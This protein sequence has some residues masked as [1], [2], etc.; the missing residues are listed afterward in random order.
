MKRLLPFLLA[1]IMLLACLAACQNV[2]EPNDGMQTQDPTLSQDPTSSDTT[3]SSGNQ[4]PVADPLSLVKDGATD[5]VIV[6]P[7]NLTADDPAFLA[8]I[9]LRDTIQEITGAVPQIV[10]DD[11]SK[12]AVSDKEIIIGNARGA[13]YNEHTVFVKESRLYIGG[14]S[15]LLSDMIAAFFKACLD[16]NIHT[17]AEVHMDQIEIPVDLTMDQAGNIT[18]QQVRKDETLWGDSIVYADEIANLI[19][20]RYLDQKRTTAE[21]TN[22]DI[23]LI[24][25]LGQKDNKQVAGLYNK[26]GV[27]YLTNTMDAFIVTESGDKLYASC[28]GSNARGNIYR[29]GYYY[30]DIHFL[31]QGF[32]P[33]AYEID[34]SA[35][36]YNLLSK[37][38]R[39]S[40]HDIESV[41]LLD[42]VLTAIVSDTYDPYFHWNVSYNTND[43][44]AIQLT[45]RTEYAT[46]ATL[47]F[48]A[49][50]YA[51]FNSDQIVSFSVA[52]G[53]EYCTYIVPLSSIPD[54]T[55]KVEAIRVD[56]G[57]KI[58]EKI[59]IKEM[60]AIK[61]N[62]TAATS[63]KLD[64]NL[65]V[66][67]DKLHQQ[68]RVVAEND[69]I[70]FKG[71]GALTKI[72]ASRVGALVIADKNGKHN[73]IDEIDTASVQYV[74]FDLI[75]A[76]VFG[77]IFPANDAYVGNV[78][79]TLEDGYY[80]IEQTYSPSSASLKALDSY[81][82][83]H[84][85]YT[86]EGHSFDELERQAYIE[87]NPLTDIK[88]VTK[89]DNANYAGYNSLVGC[90]TF[91]LNGSD[92]N[93]A[94]YNEPQKHFVVDAQIAG[95][96]YDR[97]IYVFAHSTTSGALESGVVLDEQNRLLPINVEVCKNFKGEY[98]EPLFDPEDMHYGY[99]IFPVTISKNQTKQFKSVNLYQNWGK[100]PLK[101]LSSI[102]F[103][104]PYYHLSCGVT[105]TNCIAPYYVYGKDYWT[106]PDFRAMSSPL[107]NGQPQHTS[108]GR[109]Y[110]LQY[111][112]A[113]GNFFGSESQRADISS[114]GP[115]YVDIDMS[116]LSD[117]GKIQVDYR[118]VEHAQ[119]DE[120]RTYYTLD[121]T[122][123]EDLEIKD[124]VNNFSFFSMDGR[125]IVYKKLG[126]LDENNQPQT[127]E[128]KL[129]PHTDYYK[130]GKNGAYFDYYI[131]S[132]PAH[133]TTDSVNM[134]VVI[135]DY[136]IVLGGKLYDGN[137]IL[138]E[139]YDGTVN[140]ATL[141]LDA[142]DITLRAG[143]TVHID[144]ILL[145]WGSPES[146]DDSNV[147]GVREDSVISPI[148]VKAK[149]GTVMA[150]TYLPCVIAD[151]NTA[152]FTVSD[153]GSAV[154]AVRIYGFDTYTKPNIQVYE[155]GAWIDYNYQHHDYD[156]YMSFRED[157]GTYS[158]AF[159]FEITDG[160][161][162]QFRVSQ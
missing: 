109:L 96:A 41:K 22:G 49:G 150:D 57:E 119:S 87:R 7:A 140:L 162:R 122:V 151:N 85:I 97:E 52:P 114:S 35:G 89:S 29:F 1:L 83:G 84:R 33:T 93:K 21:I 123:L 112:D 121:L 20:F 148:S 108:A 40:S 155:D 18:T 60:K 56:C 14:E 12:Y 128:L 42:D 118:Q 76:G 106:L 28:S 105:E 19:N 68:I 24:Y 36:S 154:Y 10:T 146:K 71:F 116:Y 23:L 46:N 62:T 66:Y 147:L 5:Y 78:T 144:M 124:F 79:V 120:T 65:H 43:Y 143:D 59:E 157:D 133:K 131:D 67:G 156:G 11:E 80:F 64:R 136:Q 63:M 88:I 94:Y 51:G 139:Q 75:D 142:G 149:V 99:S 125:A 134:A 17:E 81:S 95:D 107:W 4:A 69:T 32:L 77:Y 86:D 53:D 127:V 137:L 30:Y 115:V 48:K 129:E 100:F 152:E 27:P 25:N 132:N 39:P 70:G 113:D 159:S 110:W 153:G 26:Q 54:Y 111:T 138:K 34:E 135:K 103:I 92:F 130:L 6:R 73:T 82:I 101:Q 126:Y 15:Q 141:T 98:E 13:T 104:A 58:G 117:D 3:A 90:Y 16:Y 50:S 9:L 161:S 72:E 74:G 102:Q 61:I 45:M 91:T 44:N 55:G 31:N 37:A 145:P 38:R 2:E 47:Y 160:Q 8:A 158:Y